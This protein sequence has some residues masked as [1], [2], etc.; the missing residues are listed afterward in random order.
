M[1]SWL[2]VSW[3]LTVG[4][5]PLYDQGISEQSNAF[6]VYNN[7]IETT[8]SL[9]ADVVSHLKVYTSIES[10]ELINTPISYFPYRSDYKIGLALY[11]KQ[12]EIG[13]YHECDHPVLY[14]ADQIVGYGSNDTEVYIKILGETRF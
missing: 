6:L 12:I 3:G 10:Y 8:L 13:V 1:L 2:I 5:K 14:S 7:P 9:Q 11:T 4:Y